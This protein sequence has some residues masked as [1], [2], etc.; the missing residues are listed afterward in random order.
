[1]HNLGLL[2]MY[3]II[4]T[5]NSLLHVLHLTDSFR[6]FLH[7][8]ALPLAK[9]SNTE[10][11]EDTHSYKG[12]QAV[13]HSYKGLQA[14]IHSYKG[15]KAV[16]HSYK[17]LQAA[18]HSYKGV[19]SCYTQLQGATSRYTQLQGATSCYTQ[20]ESLL[21]FGDCRNN[22]EFFNSKPDEGDSF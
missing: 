3:M 10:L 18:T 8:S 4:V 9:Q 1:M 11:Q 19:T 20:N 22:V 17:G 12:L 15:L 13:T 5:R 14:V 21:Y 7:V 2:R 6:A 16:T